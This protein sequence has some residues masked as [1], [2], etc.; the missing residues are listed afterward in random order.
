[1]S[2]ELVEKKLKY[3]WKIDELLLVAEY[4]INKYK[5]NI[6]E[7]FNLSANDR[8]VFY[9]PTSGEKYNRNIVV[10]VD[11][12]DSLKS[13]QFYLI[14]VK[15][16]TN[17]QT[18]NPFRIELEEIYEIEN[19]DSPRDFIK[20]W[21]VKKGENPGDAATIASQLRLNELELYTQTERFIF[22]LIQNADDMPTEGKKVSVTMELLEDYFL[23]VHN[24]KF[25][26]RFDVQAISD[27]A[28]STKSRDKT[29][30]GYKGIGFKSVFTDSSRVYIKSGDYSFKF[31]KL[32]PDYQDF[33]KLYEGYNN[34]LSSQ[35]QIDFKQ[36]YTGKEEQFTQIERIP[37]QIKPIWVERLELPV[38]LKKSTLD[39]IIM[40]P[41]LWKSARI[42]LRKRDI[43]KKLIIYLVSPAFCFSCA[44]LP[45]YSMWMVQKEALFP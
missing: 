2:P 19:H 23:F 8:T 30:T 41:L 32:H 31:D 38:E 34:K 35:A 5:H 20:K 26:D 36:E 44:T 24:G 12:L 18:N 7:F 6:G 28:Q 43:V 27:A 9:P 42:F 21:Y 14:R 33:W 29:K 15:P 3:L 1:M 17:Q 11:H 40:L 45:Q 25:F 4:R 22:E 39:L 13:G 10:K 37:W 16:V